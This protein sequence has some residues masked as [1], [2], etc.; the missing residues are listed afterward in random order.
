MH[1]AALL[2]ELSSY[3]APSLSLFHPDI[4][5]L[6][7]CAMRMYRSTGYTDRMGLKYCTFDHNY[8]C[9]FDHK[10]SDQPDFHFPCQ[11]CAVKHSSST[12]RLSGWYVQQLQCEDIKLD[13]AELSNY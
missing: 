11:M 4:Q 9:V 8:A 10:K 2:P 5:W 6:T 7:E 1:I 3:N 12:D 13:L